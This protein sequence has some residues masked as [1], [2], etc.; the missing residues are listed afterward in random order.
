MGSR[1]ITT[2]LRDKRFFDAETKFEKKYFTL[3]SNGEITDTHEK[4]CYVKRFPSQSDQWFVSLEKREEPSRN[5]SIWA[6]YINE[7]LPGNW[8]YS[9]QVKTYSLFNFEYKKNISDLT[10]SSND[11]I[12]TIDFGTLKDTVELYW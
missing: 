6:L 3:E 2:L 12:I 7:L 10:I 9:I 4:I 5:G 1:W 8:V 11:R